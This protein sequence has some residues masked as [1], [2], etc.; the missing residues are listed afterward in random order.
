MNKITLKT[1]TLKITKTDELD[2]LT[3]FSSRINKKRGF[4]FVS[5]VLGKHIPVKPVIMKNIYNK[6]A[7]KIKIEL[8]NEPTVF[9]GFAETATALGNGVYETAN[10]KNSF[11]I[12]TTRYNLSKNRLVE[13]KEEHSHAPSHILYDFDNTEIKEIFEKATNMV[14]VDDEITTGKT[15]K[16]IVAQLKEKFPNFK[17]Y[18]AVSIL[19]WMNELDEN[20]KYIHLYKDNFSF[21]S[22]GEITSENVVSETLEKNTLDNILPS[23][24]GRFGIKNINLDFSKF[25]DISTLKNKTVLVLG[26][27][28]FMYQPYKLAEYLEKNEINTYFQATTRSPINI[29]TDIHSKIHFIDNYYENIDNFLYNV[30]DK[31]YDKVFICYETTTIP[32]THDLENQL[33]QFFEVETVFF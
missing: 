11:Y 2:S 16:N 4:L 13:F 25:I 32:D 9:I 31:K 3:G 10:L 23:N 5:K 15:L 22:N 24:L 12:H 29:D 8:N 21:E 1:G 26:T 33:K 19:N 7:E 17:N 6:L 27:G 20:L 18:Y 30:I 14:L 28:E